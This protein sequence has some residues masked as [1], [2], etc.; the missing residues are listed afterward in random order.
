MGGLD[1]ALIDAIIEYQLDLRRV[2]AGTVKS[3]L[4]ILTRM[5]NELVYTLSNQASLTELSK[6][7]KADL[8][9]QVT[10]ILNKYYLAAQGELA[11]STEGLA[12]AQAVH[13]V[14]TLNATVAVSTGATLP[15]K[16]VLVRIA[17]QVLING[18]PVAD[19]WSKLAIDTSFKLS[20]AIRQGM[21]QGETN[22]QIIN[23]VVGK[24]GQPG[25]MEI[26]KRN[27]AAVVQTATQAIAN[28]ARLKTFEAN[29]DVVVGLE[30]FSALDSHVCPVCMALSGKT[31]MN[32]EDG[33]HKPI[34]HSTPF[35]T[36]PIHFNDRC[37][38]LPI[39]NLNEFMP[40]GT[41]A[42]EGGQVPSSTTFSDWLSR[43]TQA[44]QDEQLGAGRAQ[45]WRDG[46]ITL[47]QLISG[48]GRE[49]SLAELKEKYDR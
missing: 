24:A 7:R 10:K 27:A 47:A 5:Q 36:P 28:D 11:L 15:S 22:A 32:S 38:M 43:R 26:A 8:L 14:S 4:G 49:L 23:R 34:G 20:N 48:N 35:Q 29:A 19:W 18:G 16:A 39:T 3:V 30:W 1:Q 41:R 25:I 13:T 45:M 33:S 44:Q 42:S 37:V 6:E 17:D 9:R 46:K 31:W 12:Q 40:K 2:E 21:V